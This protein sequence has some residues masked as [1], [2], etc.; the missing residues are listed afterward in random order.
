M[1]KITDITAKET[2]IF[3]L[4]GH[5]I[6]PFQNTGPIIRIF[7]MQLRRGHGFMLSSSRSAETPLSSLL[8]IL[9]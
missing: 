6:L 8:K 7:T 4:F 9:F 3:S 2:I 5:L 1:P